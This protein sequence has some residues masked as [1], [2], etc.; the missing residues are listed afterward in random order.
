MVRSFDFDGR[1]KTKDVISLRGSPLSIEVHWLS[2]SRRVFFVPHQF[3]F[4]E[5]I[6]LRSSTL[7]GS[8]I[9]SVKVSNPTPVPDFF[10]FGLHFPYD[11]NTSTSPTQNETTDRTQ[12]QV[13]LT[14][15]RGRSVTVTGTLT[16]R[17]VDSEFGTKF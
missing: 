16:R 4:V 14:S 7:Y 9:S 5:M 1:S 3:P 10:P 12:Y 13:D 17:T 6:T 11:L 2:S 15:D 8:G